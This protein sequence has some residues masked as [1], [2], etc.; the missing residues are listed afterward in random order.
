MT[1]KYVLDANAVL[2]LAEGGPGSR[3]VN[4]LLDEALQQRTEVLVSVLN[5]GRGELLPLAAAR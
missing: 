2:D 5:W 4:L 3:R 1:E